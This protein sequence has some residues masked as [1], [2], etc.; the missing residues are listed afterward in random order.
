MFFGG[1]GSEVKDEGGGDAG[2]RV[3]MLDC[4]VVGFMCWIRMLMLEE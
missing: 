4:G 2:E 3:L 1:G